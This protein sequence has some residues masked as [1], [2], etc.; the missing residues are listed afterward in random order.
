MSE[1]LQIL[2]ELINS[3]LT[4]SQIAEKLN[5]PN[6]EIYHYLTELSNKGFAFTRRYTSN[7]DIIYLPSKKTFKECSDKGIDLYTPRGD[8]ILKALLISDLHLANMKECPSLLGMFF[9]YCIKK[10]IHI[11]ICGGDFIDGLL[12]GTGKK[13]YDTAPEQIEHAISIYPHDK[14]ILT[15]TVLGNHDESTLTKAG[16]DISKAFEN[17]R[18]DI[19]CLGYGIGRLNVKNDIIIVKHKLS[20]Y[21][22]IPDPEIPDSSLMIKGHSHR[23][24]IKTT[25]NNLCIV[26]VP[27]ASDLIKD[28]YPSGAIEMELVMTDG[29]F[30]R[31]V[32][33][34]LMIIGN[35]IVRVNEIDV[36]LY[37]DKDIK[38][39]VELELTHT[40]KRMLK[41]S[42]W[43]N[44]NND[45]EV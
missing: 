24:G 6:T 23:M 13:I 43:R 31:G 42:Y 2:L 9:D 40:K 32:F 44:Q 37:F 36:P 14:S 12:S 18:H 26:T 17:Y 10:G 21:S 45:V 33:G 28:D 27:T 8:M 1:V 7:G 41:K 38:E 19:I 22:K 29:I 20:K 25:P 4:V 3:G 30:E 35:R 5:L 39:N 15:F 11:V 34:Q 16:Q